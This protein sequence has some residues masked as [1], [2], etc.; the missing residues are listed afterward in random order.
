MK[1]IMITATVLAALGIATLATMWGGSAG[2]ALA[3][4]QAFSQ[5]SM[6]IHELTVSARDLPVQSFDAF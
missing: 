1:T 2:R 6:P 3:G 4:P 5:T